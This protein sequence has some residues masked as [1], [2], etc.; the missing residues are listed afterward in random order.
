[1]VIAIDGPGGSGKSTLAA[2]L[3]DRLALDRL[4]TGAMYRAVAL[5]ALRNGV[6]PEDGA[7]VGA[8]AGRARI[9]VE[10]S[11]VRLD[12]EDVSGAIRSAPVTR[13]ASAV[14]RHPEVRGELV[15]RQRA[16][17]A[18]RGGGVVE[19]RDIGTVVCPDAD[20]KLYLTAS[21]H[22]RARRRSAELGAAEEPEVSSVAE[23]LAHRD[24]SDATRA[25]S[26]LDRAPGAVEI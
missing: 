8:L 3:A 19:G 18:A 16:W 26:P 25:A 12:G 20:L 15:A 9:E 14:A 7:G 1:M 2:A 13:A 22:E 21:P 4:D 17:V 11:T 23:E 24:R 5:A 6:A 10:G